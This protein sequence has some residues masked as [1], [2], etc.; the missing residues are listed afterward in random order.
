MPSKYSTLKSSA[1]DS[2]AEPMSFGV[3]ISTKSLS[4]TSAR[5]WRARSSVC[6]WK[7]RPP[8]GAAQVEEAPV[9]ALV[10]GRVGGDRQLGLGERVDVELLQFHLEAAELH[11]LVGDDATGDGYRG[12]GRER[13]DDLVELARRIVLAE[14]HLHGAGLVADDEKL[15]ALLVADRLHPT[16]HARTGADLGR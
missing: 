1:P 15:D 3:W 7:I 12:L 9:D 6:T 4:S 11:A 2:L 13:G 10:E 14:H 8:V 5:A 16:A